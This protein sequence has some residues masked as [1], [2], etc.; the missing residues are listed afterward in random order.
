MRLSDLADRRDAPGS[1]P[2]PNFFSGGHYFFLDAG[3]ALKKTK[4]MRVTLDSKKGS[5]VTVVAKRVRNTKVTVW[6]ISLWD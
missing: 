6:L 2:N 5:F 1:R 4:T 3:A